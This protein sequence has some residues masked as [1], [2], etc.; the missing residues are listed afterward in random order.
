MGIRAFEGQLP[1]IDPLAWVDPDAVVIGDVTLGP[2]SSVWPCAVIRGDVHHIRI[3]ARTNVQDGAVLHV[4][5]RSPFNPDGNP[6]TIGDDVTIGHAAVVHACTVG[7]RVL[8]GMNATVLDGAVVEDDVMIGAGAVVGPGKTLER[9]TLYV[10]NPARPA[11][12]L[13]D[14][15]IERLTY[16]AG[17]YVELAERFRAS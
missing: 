12:K 6:L 4:T 16:Q 15:E 9:G 13:R 10:G 11:R 5:H 2:G 17:T 1:T 8:I 14:Q 7:N 3:G